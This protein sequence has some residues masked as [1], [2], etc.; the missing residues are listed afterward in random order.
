MSVRIAATT[1]NNSY[2]DTSI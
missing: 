1:T 2:V